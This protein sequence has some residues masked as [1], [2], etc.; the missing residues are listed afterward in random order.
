[1]EHAV[2]LGYHWANAE[3]ESRMKPLAISALAVKA[4][5]KSGGS[6]SG[7]VRRRKRAETWEPIAKQMAKD[8]RAD[9]PSASQDVVATEIANGWKS[10]ECDPPGHMTLKILVSDME[11]A[12]ELPTRR[13]GQSTKAVRLTK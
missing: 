5:A 11:K 7:K 2:S 6:K 9:N 3:A 13:R 1:M 4:G 12:G 8:I 10:C